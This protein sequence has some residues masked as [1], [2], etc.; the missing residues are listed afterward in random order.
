MLLGNSPLFERKTCCFGKKV[1]GKKEKKNDYRNF[2]RFVR[3]V[4]CFF[5]LVKVKGYLLSSDILC[6]TIYT[7]EATYNFK[8]VSYNI[9]YVEPKPS[10]KSF[11][12]ILPK[13]ILDHVVAPVYRWMRPILDLMCRH[14]ARFALKLFANDGFEDI[15]PNMCVQG[16]QDIIHKNHLWA[17]LNLS[18]G[19]WEKGGKTQGKTWSNLLHFGRKPNQ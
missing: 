19:G 17:Q 10:L 7:L 6:Q 12:K 1:K 3:C 5:D 11:P 18:K 15:M 14:D 4:K 9:S 13:Y 2:S 8:H 16:R